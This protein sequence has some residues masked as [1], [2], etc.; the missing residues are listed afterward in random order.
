MSQ[1]YIRSEFGRLA[2]ALT[3]LPLFLAVAI[4]VSCGGGGEADQSQAPAADASPTAT[5]PPGMA[6]SIQRQSRLMHHMLRT[7]W[8]QLGDERKQLMEQRFE[9]G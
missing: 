1:Q 4:L 5:L 2:S 8:D 7:T 3:A 6:S 9:K